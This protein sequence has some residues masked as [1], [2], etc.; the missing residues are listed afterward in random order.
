MEYQKTDTAPLWGANA[1]PRPLG[2]DS[3]LQQALVDG[4]GAP[5]RGFRTEG[6]FN[7]SSTPG[8]Q[9]FSELSVPNEPNN[10]SRSAIVNF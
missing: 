5:D 4:T 6:F 9:A 1:K 7:P 10:G 8:G 2:V 3:L